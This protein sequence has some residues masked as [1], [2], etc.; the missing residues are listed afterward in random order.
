MKLLFCFPHQNLNADSTDGMRRPI[1]SFP[2]GI[3]MMS[4]YLRAKG[5]GGEMAIYDARLSGTFDNEQQRFGD[6]SEVISQRIKNESP[7][8]VAIS[9]MFSS[10]IGCALEVARIV[11]EIS[12][13]IVTVIGGPHASSFPLELLA[14]ND[15]DYVVMGEGEERL[16]QLLEVLEEGG[17]PKIQG[18]LGRPEDASLLKTN[19]KVPIDFIENLDDLPFPA[20]DLVD[21]ERYF[22]LQ[23]RGFSPRTIEPGKRTVTILTSR[24]C[25]HKCV[26]C[27]IQATMGYKW[28]YHSASYIQ[29]LI[30]YLIENLK[31]DYIHFEDDNFTH[32]PL[33]YDEILDVLLELKTPLKWD[34]PNGV[35][36]D[37]WT[38]ERVQKSKAAGCQFLLVSIESGVQSVI[39]NVVK[40]RLD[41]KQV[42]DLMAY[43]KKA[44]LRLY[45]CYILGL[46]GERLQD[47]NETVDFALTRYQKYNVHPALTLAMTLPGTEMYDIVMENKM[48][49]GELRYG[50]NQLTTDEFDPDTISRIYNNALQK[51]MRIMIV[52]SLTSPTEFYYNL[53]LVLNAWT[54]AKDVL[55]RTLNR[56]VKI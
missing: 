43:C 16:L 50:P 25:P 18:V 54:V 26:F 11:K 27:S 21:V 38:F 10:Q 6:S 45:A 53:K 19:P 48:F 46:P 12:P 55:K 20:Y 42:D 1:I 5:W 32:D 51:K 3:L 24:G 40:K 4:A 15:V 39:D 23:S 41:L 7:D 56:Y 49:N 31:I 8:V 29:R 14:Q 17:E 35:R 30:G 28:R 2:L 34:T 37:T 36:G 33:R 22:Y 47:I 44:K 52:K 13:D 9:N